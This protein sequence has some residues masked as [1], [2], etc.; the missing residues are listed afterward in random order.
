MSKGRQLYDLQEIDSEIDAKRDA[1]SEVMSR[2]DD[3]EVVDQSRLSLARDEE[4]LADLER[5]Q[6][7]LEREVEDL[8]A[9]AAV[10]EER[11]YGGTVK[12]PKELASL[13]EQVANLKRRM[14]GLDD[15]TLDIMSDFETVHQQVSSKRQELAK[16]EEEWQEE[17]ASLS[18]EQAEL[19]SALATLEQKRKDLA[20]KLDTAS[21]ELYQALR[22][23]RQGKA[24]A[25]VEQGVCQGCRIALPMSEMQRAKIGQELVQCSSC[26]RI[27]YLS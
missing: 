26:E 22:R 8:Q 12:I 14:K 17:Q 11:L 6:R 21:L 9:K 27:L 23:I 24:V 10:S 2:L 25:K 7:E 13:Q 19:N 4:R 16:V 1:L 3:S 20:S 5:S 18:Q 15:K